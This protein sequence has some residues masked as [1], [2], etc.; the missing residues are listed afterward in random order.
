LF[1]AGAVGGSSSFGIAGLP[2]LQ[3]GGGAAAAAFARHHHAG[4][5]SLMPGWHEGSE[6]TN[7]PKTNSNRSRSLRVLLA[8]WWR[9]IRRS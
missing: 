2:G 1:L 3:H 9:R 4:R 8:E 6:K 7:L 5:E